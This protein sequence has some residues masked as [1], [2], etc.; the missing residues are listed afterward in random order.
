VVGL[1]LA[2]RVS[3]FCKQRRLK[4]PDDALQRSPFGWR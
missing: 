4:Q 1:A 3:E 2:T